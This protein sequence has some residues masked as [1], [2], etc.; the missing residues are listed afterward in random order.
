M[1]TNTLARGVHVPLITP[2]TEAGEVA[3]DALERLARE[4]LEEGA[5]G[6]VALGTTAEV[7]TL[8][9]AEREAVVDVVARVCRERG[10]PLTV[11][12]GSNATAASK[13]ALAALGKRPEVVAALTLVPY[14][15]RPSEAG[16][17]AHF[18]E[19]AA[20]SP[21]PLIVYHIPYRTGQEL[22]ARTLREL[23]ALP[24]I[25]GV[26]YAAGGITADTVALMADLPAD[27]AVFAGD[28]VFF[29]PLLAMGAHGGILASAHLATGA[30]ASLVEAWRAG[31]GARARE[32]GHRLAALS[33][34]LFAEPNP[35]VV[36]GVLHAQ[37]RIPSPG[38]RLPLLSARA[39]SV[40]GALA[41]LD[42]FAGRP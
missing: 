22:G 13:E 38:V 36:K 11:G 12:A 4:L 21:V 3:L 9:D 14:F 40:A 28:D 24:G 31:D 19:L 10:A 2:F 7:S 15:T 37:G 23:G 17:L 20:H 30:F 34:T 32:L 42:A 18:A 27:F 26:K 33:A 25:A 39:G 6:L 8:T 41:A 35:T 5:A 29:S 1:G 16:V